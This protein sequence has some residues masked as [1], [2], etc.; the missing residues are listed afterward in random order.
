MDS[1]NE[2]FTGAHGDPGE[3][4]TGDFFSFPV[5]PLFLTSEA[6]SAGHQTKSSR[7]VE[8]VF[9]MSF[10]ILGRCMHTAV[11]ESRPYSSIYANNTARRLRFTAVGY[12]S[13]Y[14]RLG[15]QLC[16]RLQQYMQL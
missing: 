12:T 15:A 11:G 1:E 16:R 3:F 10:N 14:I 7:E 9:F 13:K 5:V 8:H 2:K 4:M 6:L